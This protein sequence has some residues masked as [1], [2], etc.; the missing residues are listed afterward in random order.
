MLNRTIMYTAASSMA[1]DIVESVLGGI[2]DMETSAFNGLRSCIVARERS[3][4]SLFDNIAKLA[5]QPAVIA[6]W[7]VV[8][9]AG[10]VWLEP[11]GLENS[12]WKLPGW[13]IPGTKNLFTPR[14]MFT[15]EEPKKG[16]HCIPMIPFYL[17]GVF[18]PT[19]ASQERNER[20]TMGLT[21]LLG[22]AVILMAIADIMPKN[23]AEF[24][25]L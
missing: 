16:L 17:S 19:L 20:V 7:V 18:S 10:I 15:R 13:N 2:G 14:K 21:A 12:D 25:I 3:V 9:V 6:I 22:V 8:L 24:P 5:S 23:P 1:P 4:G 11:S